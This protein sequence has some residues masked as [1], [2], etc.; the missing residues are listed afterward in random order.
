MSARQEL[1]ELLKLR[2]LR[3]LAFTA[4][5]GG[6]GT[7]CL[8]TKYSVLDPDVWWH[9]TVGDWIVQHHA[10]PHTGIFSQTAA[11]RPWMA[12]SWGYEV[13]LSRAYAWFGLAGMGL[14]GMAL[15]LAVAGAMFWMLQ[16]LSG[17]FWVAWTLSIAACYAFLFTLMPRPVFFSMALFTITLTLILEA[18]RSGRVQLLYWLPLIFMLWAN[19]HIQFIYGLFLVGLL[20]ALTLLERCASYLGL[21]PNLLP[22]P[23]LPLTALM[24]VFGACVMASCIGPYSFHLYESVFE[25]AKARVP[26]SM[27]VELQALSFTSSIHFLEL[28]LAAGAFFAVGWQS[29]LDPFKVAVLAIA[30][31]VAFRTTRDAWFICIPAAAFIA[32]FR[33]QKSPDEPTRLPEYAGVAVGLALLLLL[34]ARNTDYSTRGLDRAISR[35]FP[36]NAVNF[37]RKNPV[38]GPLYNSFDWGG[39]LIWY[40][41]QYPVAIDGRTDIYGDA[42]V[43]LFYKTEAAD[44]SYTKDPYLSQA[45]LVLLKTSVPLAKM[46]TAD[47]RFRV[48]YRDEIAVIFVRQ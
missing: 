39:F 47:S 15:T 35:D 32:D 44:P 3:L 8:I 4:L 42:L 14:F 34:I 46:L 29:K 20:V 36:V 11:S 26:Y 7:L 45:G 16:R 17:R 41:P 5:L 18:R 6:V 13:L 30:C 21:R 1:R 48:L 28:L 31:A 19:L 38:P 24:G 22:P 40:M 33:A 23:T 2:T 10:V 25:I 27:I 12:Y 43:D 37:L 9:L